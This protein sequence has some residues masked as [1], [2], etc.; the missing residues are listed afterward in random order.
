MVDEVQ[1]P[2]PNSGNGPFVR[3]RAPS[4]RRRK[5]ACRSEADGF[6]AHLH[7]QAM[8]WAY[9]DGYFFAAENLAYDLL[10]AEELKATQREREFYGV[11]LPMLYCYRHY[12]ELALK[13]QIDLWSRVSHL[14][15]RA[16]LDTTHAL[17]PLWN[18]VKRHQARTTPGVE[19]GDKTI[20]GVE[21]SMN[22]F[23]QYDPKSQTFRYRLNVAGNK[24][25]DQL[26][27]TDLR[28]LIRTMRGLKNYFDVQHDVVERIE[29]NR[30]DWRDF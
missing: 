25:D 14:P 3:R 8:D 15:R 20:A 9:L 1:I 22:E 24:H 6:F 12:L 26:P 16:R 28:N 23:H 4:H 29:S 7:D 11:G 19:N 10:N 5:N 2:W 27:K 21:R 18:E 13:D 17:M 30:E